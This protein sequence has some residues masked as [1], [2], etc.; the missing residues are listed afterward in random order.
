MLQQCNERKETLLYIV[1]ID[2]LYTY[3]IYIY[4]YM[5]RVIHIYIYIHIAA[6]IFAAEV[7]PDPQFAV[8]G[9]GASETE[10]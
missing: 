8:P 7:V 6:S 4:I 3:I 9:S 2:I 5:I 1:Y 10:L